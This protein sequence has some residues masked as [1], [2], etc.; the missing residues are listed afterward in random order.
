MLYTPDERDTVQEEHNIPF[1]IPGAP[2]PCVLAT[3]QRLLLSYYSE[4]RAP[5]AAPGKPVL[6]NETFAGTVVIVDFRLPVSFFSVPLS[7][8][9]LQ[10][11]P[12][13]Y[14][15]LVSYRV[16]QVEDSSW[17]R[18]LTSANLFI[19]DRTQALSRRVSTTSSRFT[20]LFL[21]L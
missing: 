5:A 1:P 18:A 16:F 11:H 4:L 15:G 8:E 3:E 21:K 14:R 2:L 7:N 13:F 12:F 6:V 10:A 17:I 9:T 20:I 19:Q